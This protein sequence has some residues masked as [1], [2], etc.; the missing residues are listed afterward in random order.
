[1]PLVPFFDCGMSG[2]KSENLFTEQ[3][4]VFMERKKLDTNT[5][6]KHY[7]VKDTPEN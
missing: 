4:G 1:M 3:K 2:I 6:F 7:V 5:V